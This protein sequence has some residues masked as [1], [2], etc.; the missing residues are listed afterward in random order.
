MF[1]ITHYNIIDYNVATMRSALS[2][3]EY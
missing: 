3:A 2:F 1:A